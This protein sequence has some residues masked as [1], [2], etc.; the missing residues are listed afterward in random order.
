M[1]NLP[2]IGI[3]VAVILFAFWALSSRRQV[4]RARE[5]GLWP[6]GKTPTD[7]DVKCLVDAGEKILAIKLCRQVHKMGLAEAKAHVEKMAEPIE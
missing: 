1:D 3:S 4:D 2:I 6:T 5:H 7:A